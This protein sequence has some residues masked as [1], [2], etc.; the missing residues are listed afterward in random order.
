MYTLLYT[1]CCTIWNF[2]W[3]RCFPVNFVKFLRTPF[4]RNTSGRLLPAT[5]YCNYSQLCILL[6]DVFCSTIW[7]LTEYKILFPVAIICCI[8]TIRYHFGNDFHEKV[9]IKLTI[10]EYN[11]GQGAYI[12]YVEGGAGGFYK[13]FKNFFVAQE[14]KDLQISWPSNFFR[15]YFM[16]PPIN[17]SFLFKAY[18]QQYFRE[19]LTVIFKFQITK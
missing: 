5:P 10:V 9:L 3:H 17:F 19:V 12:K 6:L 1:N 4:S 15:K 16:A 18:L 13:F 7:N 8:L 14:T 2:D 11:Y